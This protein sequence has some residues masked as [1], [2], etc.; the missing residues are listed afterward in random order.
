MNWRRGKMW[1]EKIYNVF[2]I[3]SLLINLI[4]GIYL[5]NESNGEA[6][7]YN[8]VYIN[9]VI[10]EPNVAKDVAEIYFEEFLEGYNILSKRDKFT[11]T[12]MFDKDTYEWV[13]VYTTT[14][15]RPVTISSHP[16]N[17]SYEIRLRMD[18]GMVEMELY[19]FFKYWN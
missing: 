7:D 14:V 4:S 15:E 5:I 1:K 18:Y 9:P 6:I 12:V 17:Y 2:L 16:E 11:T 10:T 8:R 19:D 13:V 3:A